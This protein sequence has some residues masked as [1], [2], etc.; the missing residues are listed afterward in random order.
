M[1]S[2]TQALELA[3]RVAASGKAPPRVALPTF[4][5]YDLLSAAAGSRAELVFYDLD[6]ATLGPCLDD[7]NRV[8]LLDPDCI[9][10]A[11]LFGS[12]VDVASVRTAMAPS[13]ALLVEDAAQG[14]GGSA[15]GI[16]L[17]GLG[18]L[19]V[20]SFGRG[21]GWTG[22]GGGALLLPEQGRASPEVRERF[23]EVMNGLESSFGRE[24]RKK[25][26]SA[27]AAHL[28]ARPRLYGV[29]AALPWLGL[30]ETHYDPPRPCVRMSAATA[31]LVLDGEPAA[32]KEAAVRKANAR[33]LDELLR[34]VDPQRSRWTPVGS[35]SHEDRGYLRFPARLRE[36]DQRLEE[37]PQLGRLGVVGSY[38]RPLPDVVRSLGLEGVSVLDDGDASTRTFPGARTL[39]SELVT[40]PTH[41]RRRRSWEAHLA[42]VLAEDSEGIPTSRTEPKPRS[43]RSRPIRGPTRERPR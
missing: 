13:S 27:L 15:N 21:K 1:G 42:S 32:L 36:R 10:V 37:A 34:H 2:G 14:H 16:P 6:P 12:P 39:A 23:L 35:G 24:G 3:F 30:G 7:L 18:D 25:A 43:E 11:H 28:C 41:S 17:G 9:V 31:R 5:C 19:S 20:L 8:S 29:P 38:P 4:A 40:L 33:V 22:G 26:L